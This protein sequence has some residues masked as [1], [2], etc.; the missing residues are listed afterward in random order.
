MIS[1]PINVVCPF[2]ELL[3]GSE[4]LT[5]V[6][7]GIRWDGNLHKLSNKMYN[8]FENHSTH[9]GGCK[10][11]EFFISCKFSVCR[12]SSTNEVDTP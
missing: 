7:S 2:Q 3:R 9:V 11:E 8:S 6:G 10:V 1:Y 5:P 12:G 4:S